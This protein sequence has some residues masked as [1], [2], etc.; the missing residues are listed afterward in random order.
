MLSFCTLANNESINMRLIKI[1]EKAPEFASQSKKS[2]LDNIKINIE[3][4]KLI[5]AQS[6]EFLKT[7][8]EFSS[9]VVKQLNDGQVLQG[10]DLSTI[11][12]MIRTMLIVADF[13]MEM[14]NLYRKDLENESTLIDGSRE[15]RMKFLI[16]YAGSLNL[17]NLFNEAYNQFFSNSK[18]RRIVVDIYKTKS[19]AYPNLE[20]AHDIMKTVDNDKFRNLLKDRTALFNEA[21]VPLLQMM[22]VHITRLV[23]TIEMMPISSVYLHTEYKKFKYLRSSDFIVAIF[24]RF[25]NFISGLFG[26]MVGS[27][28]WRHGYLYEHLEA[29]KFLSERLKP[30]DIIAE[31]TPFAATDLFI[32]GHFGHIALYLG[33]EE[34]LREVGL[35]NTPLIIPHQA[36]IRAGKVILESIRPGSRLTTLAHFME[37]DEITIIRQKNI[38]DNYRLAQKTLEVGLEQ[39]GK[40]YD[41][42][43]DVHTLDKVVCSEVAYHAYGH[44]KWPTAYL[45]GRYTIS[46]DDVI[47]LAFWDKSPV[48]FELSIISNKEKEVRSVD[49]KEMA[50]NLSFEYNKKRSEATGIASFDKVTKSCFTVKK[51]VHGEKSGANFKYEKTCKN[52]YKQLVYGI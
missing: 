37:I 19:K 20:K 24:G 50:K 4:L 2:D 13:N 6:D 48:G 11:D 18:L 17:F 29:Q 39:L 27:I 23:A 31:K 8:N 16:A 5:I 1:N 34:Q 33:T 28:R 46:P 52:Q 43:F 36:D 15:D 22:N 40:D 30:L 49:V 32:P 38:L 7:T 42:N 9:R 12:N 3:K 21:R 25:T 14:I 45:F 35:W 10:D 44:V 51:M 26:N 47:S 41:F